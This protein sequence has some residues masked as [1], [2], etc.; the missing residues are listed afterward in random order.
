MYV[1]SRMREKN[2]ATKWPAS[3]PLEAFWI[4]HGRP[5]A[6]PKKMSSDPI[7][8]TFSL[9]ALWKTSCSLQN[10]TRAKS[11]PFLL[12]SLESDFDKFVFLVRVGH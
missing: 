2:R 6:T 3:L 1:F 12:V 5:V 11:S 4:F 10:L 9:K 8:F 7:K